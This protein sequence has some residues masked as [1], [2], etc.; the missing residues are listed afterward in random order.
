MYVDTHTV[1]IKAR[2]VVVYPDDLAD[3]SNPKPE[4]GEELNRPAVIQ[5]HGYWPKDKTT[6]APIKDEQRLEAMNYAAKLQRLVVKIGG[7][8][9]EYKPATGSCIFKVRACLVC[10]C[11][12]GLCLKV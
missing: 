10:V 1:N 9:I 2:E 3:P 5:M 11:G 4:V 8:F 6:G 7:K 12:R